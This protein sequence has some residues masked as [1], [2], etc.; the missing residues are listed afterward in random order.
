MLSELM[1]I[2]LECLVIGSFI[3]MF[4]TDYS[5]TAFIIFMVSAINSIAEPY[6]KGLSN[7]ANLTAYET[8]ALTDAITAYF[9]YKFGDFGK[10]YIPLI[11]AL[12]ILTH[13]AYLV[14]YQ[15]SLFTNYSWYSIT[16]TTLNFIQLFCF[17][18]GIYN[19]VNQLGNRASIS[20][21]RNRYNFTSLLGEKKEC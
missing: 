21:Y 5:R 9:V 4:A 3:A 16:L 2:S 20:R 1:W 11:L 19:V 12:F 18:E 7:S 15:L 8:I 14:A 6:I 17:R 10:L 13:V